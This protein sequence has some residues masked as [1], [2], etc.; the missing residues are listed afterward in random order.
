M[1]VANALRRACQRLAQ[2][3]I[4]AGAAPLRWAAPGAPEPALP[5]FLDRAFEL[6]QAVS[7]FWMQTEQ[8]G[9]SAACK[10]TCPSP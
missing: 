4:A 3:A 7:F 10:I 8:G 5:A 6:G 2:R 1:S 9:W